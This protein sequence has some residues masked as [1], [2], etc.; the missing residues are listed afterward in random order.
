MEQKLNLLYLVNY[1]V[2]L[3][4][5]LTEHLGADPPELEGPGHGGLGGHQ[6][7]VRLEQLHRVAVPCHLN[8]F[9]MIVQIFFNFLHKYFSINHTDIFQS[10]IY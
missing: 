2:Y 5:P 6:H 1:I 9:H 3:D 8:I 10:F 7:A 4:Y